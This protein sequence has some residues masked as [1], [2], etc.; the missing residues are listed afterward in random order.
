MTISFELEFNEEQVSFTLNKC[1]LSADFRVL[2]TSIVDSIESNNSNPFDGFQTF[3]EA[4][5]YNSYEWDLSD[6][7][8]CQQLA[9]AARLAY[10]ET[11]KSGDIENH[12]GNLSE[13]IDSA[14]QS[15]CS[16]FDG[17]N[18]YGCVFDEKYEPLVDLIIE[19]LVSTVPDEITPSI[20]DGG[21]H[22]ELRW[23]IEAKLEEQDASEPKDIIPNHTLVEL[24]FTKGF[25]WGESYLEDRHTDH[26]YN[27][28]QVDTMI[29]DDKVQPLFDMA[30]INPQEFAEY[31]ELNGY[32]KEVVERYKACQN[33]SNKGNAQ[34]FSFEYLVCVLDNATYGGIPTFTAYVS[35]HDFIFRDVTKGFTLSNGVLG[36]EDYINGSGHNEGIQGGE[37]KIE[38]TDIGFLHFPDKRNSRDNVYGFAISALK[39]EIQQ[40]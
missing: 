38:T 1:L 31:L 7:E 32:D 27:V 17:G 23:A 22:D 21:L 15:M 2:A 39:S 20:H 34:L 18:F 26:D 3:F 14:L 28:S 25:T 6:R 29:V 13:A 19:C 33:N 8:S 37:L 30:N 4:T 11:L 16:N 9:E 35:A 24:N 5:K 12:D 10:L 40:N 36:I